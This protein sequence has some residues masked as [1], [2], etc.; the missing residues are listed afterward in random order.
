MF[1]VRLS[2]VT[3]EAKV[4]PTQQSIY[5]LNNNDTNNVNGEKSQKPE[6]CTK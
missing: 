6:P 5:D 3:S 4:L 2:L 1:T